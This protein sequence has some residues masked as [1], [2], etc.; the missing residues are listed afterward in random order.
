MESLARRQPHLLQSVGI[1]QIASGSSADSMINILAALAECWPPSTSTNGQSGVIVNHQPGLNGSLNDSLMVMAR[2]GSD[3]SR[4][5]SGL[6]SSRYV[7]ASVNSK[8]P[9]Q[10]QR[11]V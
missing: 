1:G 10:I 11:L 4:V 7:I 9:F 6:G 2:P 8:S 5:E 3:E